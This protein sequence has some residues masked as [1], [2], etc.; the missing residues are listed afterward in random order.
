MYS[1]SRILHHT[2][3]IDMKEK[4][5]KFKKFKISQNLTAINLNYQININSLDILVLPFDAS[6]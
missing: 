6:E 2:Y 3:R 4:S 1:Y 5:C